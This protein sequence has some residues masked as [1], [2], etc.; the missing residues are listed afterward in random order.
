MTQKKAR[1]DVTQ[2]KA[3]KARRRAATSGVAAAAP[4]VGE[5]MLCST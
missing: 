1:L 2:K 4:W 5:V 3:R